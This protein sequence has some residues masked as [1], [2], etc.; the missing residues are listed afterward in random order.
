MESSFV[1]LLHYERIVNW[2]MCVHTCLGMNYWA[3][4]LRIACVYF[5]GCVKFIY[6]Y[7]NIKCHSLNDVPAE[8]AK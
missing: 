6:I 7:L 3:F 2:R 5:I 4:E 8:T 1:Y